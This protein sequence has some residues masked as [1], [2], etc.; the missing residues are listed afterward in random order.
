MRELLFLRDQLLA[1]GYDA[2]ITSWGGSVRTKMPS[3]MTVELGYDTFW[4]DHLGQPVLEPE[5][6][7]YK[8]RTKKWPDDPSATT[9]KDGLRP[10]VFALETLETIAQGFADV[11]GSARV[12]VSWEDARRRDVYD[13]VLGK[14]GYYFT[15]FDGHKYLE[16]IYHA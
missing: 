10:A 14:R 13:K 16:K 6:C 11:Y 3:G 4:I 1:K 8:K 7:V 12:L 5:L 9:G 15:T 2:D